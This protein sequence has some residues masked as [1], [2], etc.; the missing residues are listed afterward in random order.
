MKQIVEKMILQTVNNTGSIMP[1]FKT[2]YAYSQVMNW[3]N[4]LE[5]EGLI[6]RD[7]DGIR[8][9]TKLGLDKLVVYGNVSEKDMCYIQPLNQYKTNKMGVEDVFL[10]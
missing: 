4:E 10:P 9:L 6:S 8:I 2:G 1:L 7:D 3:C 5:K